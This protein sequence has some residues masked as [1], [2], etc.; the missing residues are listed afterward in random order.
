MSCTRLFIGVTIFLVTAPALTAQV[1]LPKKPTMQQV[2]GHHLGQ[3][4]SWRMQQLPVNSVL[5]KYNTGIVS[6]LPQPFGFMAN[7]PSVSFSST[8]F[9]YSISPGVNAG[10]FNSLE[11]TLFR[12]NIIYSQT[13]K[14]SWWKD[15]QK[16]PGS[17][18]LRET[19]F[20]NTPFPFR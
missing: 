16:A 8:A 5:Y 11:A 17:Q 20:Q 6:R 9:R 15:P 19:F 10:Q 3:Q 7:T 1:M 18:I 14:Q 2:I 13:Q 4:E 12:Q